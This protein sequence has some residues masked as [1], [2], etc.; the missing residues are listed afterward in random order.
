MKPFK[1]SKEFLGGKKVLLRNLLFSD[2]SSHYLS[3]LKDSEVS[4][5]MSLNLPTTIKQLKKYYKRMDQSKRDTIFAITLKRNKRHI[6]NISIQ[7][8]NR[9]NRSA[10]F[11]I[12]IGDKREWNKG[13]GEEATSLVLQYGFS[14]LGVEKIILGVHPAHK[15]AVKVYRKSGF[16]LIRKGRNKI[17]MQIEKNRF[18]TGRKR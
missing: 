1:N 11:G 4:K 6:G 2:V 12:M 7:K 17:Q 3:W 10:I 18:I 5:F 8:I 15:S 13:Y 9:R 16:R 14:S